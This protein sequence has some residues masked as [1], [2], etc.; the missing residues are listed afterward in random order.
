MRSGSAS[1]LVLVGVLSLLPAASSSSL[2]DQ[3][4][5]MRREAQK[6]FSVGDQGQL[7]AAINDLKDQAHRAHAED[8]EL[9]DLSEQDML[10]PSEDEESIDPRA[11]LQGRV[12]NE[13]EG[14]QS[15][16]CK[17]M[18]KSQTT[19]N[20]LTEPQCGW[21]TK[22]PQGACGTG[23]QGNN[24]TKCC[25]DCKALRAN[26]CKNA[27]SGGAQCVWRNGKC[28]YVSSSSFIYNGAPKK[29]EEDEEDVGFNSALQGDSDHR[30][31]LAVRTGTMDCS[32]RATAESACNRI[33]DHACGWF[34][35]NTQ[36]AT[37]ACAQCSALGEADCRKANQKGSRC[38]WNAAGTTCNDGTSALS[39]STNTYDGGKTEKGEPLSM[40]V[41]ED[42]DE[43]ENH[44]FDARD[45]L[46]KR[47]DTMS[48]MADCK[49]QVTAPIDKS[50]GA[51]CNKATA[52]Q[53]GWNS[54]L[55]QCRDCGNLTQSM[56]DAAS[57]GGSKCTWVS[58]KKKCTAESSSLL[59]PTFDGSPS[60]FDA[61]IKDHG[62]L[63]DDSVE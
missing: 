19:C 58:D 42:E 47:T 36:K 53:C 17:S 57:S 41:D 12:I 63:E 5:T 35:G 11:L 56:C 32:T 18:G 6:S 48:G 15:P 2:T 40:D 22:F 3:G 33:S 16:N 14:D 27:N 55:K 45:L 44:G 1:T 24:R 9:K 7:H 31:L 13:G 30:D 59:Q 37:P 10:E 51:T 38:N 25:R 52:D 4:S 26:D 54:D 49:S 21:A 34:S 50:S 28:R 8:T 61:P 39:L 43:N 62:E 23:P 29:Q 20:S 46:T 60:S